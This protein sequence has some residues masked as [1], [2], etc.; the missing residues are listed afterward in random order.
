MS[1]TG[2]KAGIGLGTILSIVSSGSPI[3]D[4]V[5]GEL[6]KCSFTGRQAGTADVTNFQSAAKEFIPTLID[7]GTI[8]ISGNRIGSDAGQLAM[9]TAFTSLQLHAFTIQ[10]PKSQS[11]INAGDSCSFTALIEQLN[12]DVS[13]D[14]IVTL[15]GRLKVSGILTWTAGS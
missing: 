11:Q 14:K 7:S 9:E 3:T 5:V 13:V 2:S 4:T 10:L 12:Y 6:N 1:Y 15:E 8:E